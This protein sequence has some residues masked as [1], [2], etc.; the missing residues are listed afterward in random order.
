MSVEQIIKELQTLGKESYKNTMKKHGVPEPFFGVKIGDMKKILKRIKQDHQLALDLFDT[1]NYDAMYLAGYLVDDSK[2]TNKDLK[3]WLKKA[4]C[5][6]LCEYT[7]P[8]VASESKH[9]YEI[10]LEWIDAKN[11]KTAAAGWAVMGNLVSVKDD[12]ELDIT[13]L[14][15]LLKQ[16]EKTIHSQPGRVRLWMNSYVI[17]LG[18]Y[19]KELT[20][21]AIKVAEKIG[22]VTVDM[23]ETSCKVPDAVPYI[24]KVQDRGTIGKK[25]KTAKC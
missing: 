20:N 23:G 6:M 24:K 12:T 17:A 15:R 7:V 21:N 11:E 14:K 9:G 13:E 10:A 1:G 8:W 5:E 16:V 25:R 19:V 18:C 3:S 4:H 22:K 2:M